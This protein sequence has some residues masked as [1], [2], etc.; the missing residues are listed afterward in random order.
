MKLALLVVFG[1][2]VMSFAVWMTKGITRAISSP[3][4]KQDKKGESEND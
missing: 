2:V 4:P 1:V 3:I